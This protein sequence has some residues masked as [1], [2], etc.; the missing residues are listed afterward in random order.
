MCVVQGD[1]CDFRDRMT[2]NDAVGT[3]YL[4]LAK[5]ASSGGEVEGIMFCNSVFISMGFMQKEK[6]RLQASVVLFLLCLN[7]SFL[8]GTSFVFVPLK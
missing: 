8:K 7:V 2:G 1:L 5:I 6:Q 4:N 3:T